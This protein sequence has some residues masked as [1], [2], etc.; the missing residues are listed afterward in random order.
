MLSVADSQSCMDCKVSD[1]HMPISRSISCLTRHNYCIGKFVGLL[2]CRKQV[3]C[4]YTSDV[5]DH[6][7]TY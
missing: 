2:W 4:A 5:S 1:L 6:S 7:Y 3:T